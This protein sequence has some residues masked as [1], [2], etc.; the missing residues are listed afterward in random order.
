MLS[1]D[2]VTRVWENM[3]SAEARSLYFGNLGSR[4]TRYKQWITGS[5][6]FFSSGAAAAIIGKAPQWVPILL[7]VLSAGVTAYAIA[8]NLDKR[9]GTMATLHS[10]WSQIAAEYYHL[11][12]HTSD[13]DAEDQ[14]ARI[15]AREK[16]PSELAITSAPYN[17]KLLGHWED[18]VLRMYHLEPA[19]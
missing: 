16:E 18:Q 8:V 4:D 14:L 12:N 17:K 11:W 10:S 7:A 2:Q 1:E 3:L 15:I 19:T 9:V 6:F 5:S 13:E